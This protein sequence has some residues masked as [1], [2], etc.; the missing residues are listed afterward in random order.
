MKFTKS[1]TKIA[2]W[3]IFIGLVILANLG[4]FAVILTIYKKIIGGE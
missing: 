4:I 2:I 1:I 3:T